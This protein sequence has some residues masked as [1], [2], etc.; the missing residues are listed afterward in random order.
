MLRVTTEAVL[1]MRF[2]IYLKDFLKVRLLSRTRRKVNDAKNKRIAR[3]TT[4]MRA[5]VVVATP[6]MLKAA[7]RA[8]AVAATWNGKRPRPNQSPHLVSLIIPAAPTTEPAPRRYKNHMDVSW[9]MN[10]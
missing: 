1:R 7:I 6:G 3:E 2:T 9:T 8:Y 10:G 5:L 4:K